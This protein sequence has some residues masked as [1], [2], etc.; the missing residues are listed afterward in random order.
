MYKSPF[1]KN[2]LRKIVS[3]KNCPVEINEVNGEVFAIFWLKQFFQV[4]SKKRTFTFI[5][6]M[7]PAML[8]SIL[9]MIF[10]TNNL[11]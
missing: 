6:G 1:F 4:C 7:L 9:E 11:Q 3:P 5:L 10:L 2:I 8:V